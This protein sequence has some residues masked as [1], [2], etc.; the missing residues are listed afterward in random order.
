MKDLHGFAELSAA[1]AH[2]AESGVLKGL[3][4]RPIRLNGKNHA[5]TNYLLQS[6]GAICKAWVIEANRM[7]E[8]GIGL[9]LEFLLTNRAGL[10]HP[11]TQRKQS[12]SSNKVSVMSN[13]NS[14][15][16]LPLSPSSHRK[17]LGRSSLISPQP[18]RRYHRKLCT[19]ASPS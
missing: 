7:K 18:Q 1:I 8:A 3:D 13:T 6:C 17:Q 5:A 16:E 14:T 10:L 4:G 19:N 11:R 9:P 12:K 2:K 15:S